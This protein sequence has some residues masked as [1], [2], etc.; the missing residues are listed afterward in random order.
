MRFIYAALAAALAHTAASS[1][2]PA[3]LETRVIPAP[4]DCEE[5]GKYIG[6]RDGT[7]AEYSVG[8]ADLT[9]ACLK[10][11]GTS[12][13]SHAECV[14]A[15]TCQ[16][17]RGVIILNQCQNH[18]VA[19][20]ASIPNLSGAVYAT[21]VG[22]AAAAANAPITQQNYIDFVFGQMSAA[23]VTQWPTAA[24]VISNWWTPIKTWTATGNSIP[25]SNFN[26]WLHYSETDTD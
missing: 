13:W 24:E 19:H 2:V 12:I 9:Y 11:N 25:Y 14:A 8:C 21:I 26:D 7:G 17:T 20:A 1:A 18:N 5:Y 22:S 6:I 10:L 3:V 4:I 16:G 15:A 23:G